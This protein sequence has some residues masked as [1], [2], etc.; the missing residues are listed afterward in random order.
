MLGSAYAMRILACL[1]NDPTS[2]REF[3]AVMPGLTEISCNYFGQP[4]AVNWLSTYHPQYGIARI[5]CP[6]A[7]RKI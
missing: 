7:S 1:I 5:D 2:C 4:A 3:Q 6:S